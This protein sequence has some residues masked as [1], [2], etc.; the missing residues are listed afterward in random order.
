[1]SSINSNENNSGKYDPTAAK[2][3]AHVTKEEKRFKKLLGAIYN[4]C[5]LSGYHLEERIVVKD[6][7]TGKV[8]R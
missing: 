1:M 7:R 3:I 2:A 6:K 4:I 5:E 8:W